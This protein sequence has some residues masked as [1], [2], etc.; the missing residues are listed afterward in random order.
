MSPTALNELPFIVVIELIMILIGG[1]LAWQHGL[2]S[3]GRQRAEQRASEMPAWNVSLLNF[4]LFLWFIFCGGLLAQSI[5]SLVLKSISVSETASL[6]IAG[7]S[8]HGGML[9]GVVMF[10]FIFDRPDQSFRVG[11]STGGKIA[12][13]VATFLIVLPILTIVGLVWQNLLHAL[14]IPIEAQDLIGIF[15]NTK[16]PL[17]F[18]LMVLLATVVAPITEELIF[19]AGFFRYART[20]F[21]RWIALLVPALLF[22]ALHANLASFVPLAALGVIF[23]LAYE[24]TGSIAVPMIAHGLFN[25]NT[26]LLILAGVG[27]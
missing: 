8:F 10:K 3:A 12:A 6:I 21:S 16:S 5:I 15:A 22:G 1:Y 14:G 7:G 18:S 20:R 19:R 11:L 26:I 23:S 25:L 2:S 4:F 9:L 27:V 13:G 24:R 17:L